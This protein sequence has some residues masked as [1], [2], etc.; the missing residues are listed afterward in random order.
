MFG[1]SMRPTFFL[2]L[3]MDIV[4]GCD[5]FQIEVSYK[6]LLF[7]VPVPIT[8]YP[9]VSADTKHLSFHPPVD[10]SHPS[11]PESCQR[12]CLVIKYLSD[13]FI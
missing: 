11:S 4:Q 10:S 7:V 13:R 6:C 2:V 1:S 9:A 8:V 12:L 3:L 5:S